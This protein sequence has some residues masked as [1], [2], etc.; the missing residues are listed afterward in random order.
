MTMCAWP[1]PPT[2]IEN[3]GNT[4]LVYPGMVEGKNLSDP[5][6]G[7]FTVV[8]LGTGLPRIDKIPATVRPYRQVT[9][10]VTGMNA[11]QLGE[12]L[13]KIADPEAVVDFRF[14][15]VLSFLPDWP[16]LT[17]QLKRQYYYCEVRMRPLFSTRHSSR[18][19]RRTNLAG[20]FFATDVKA[21]GGGRHPRR[22][23]PQ[24]FGH[25]ERDRGFT[26]GERTWVALS[27]SGCA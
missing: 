12:E 20:G 10:D 27:L 8:E 3:G 1:Y 2:S 13:K 11:A 4:L 6:T 24:L 5:G 15:G 22:T 21:D 23:A 18:R 26:R 14:T 25:G 7:F 16:L 17:E 9:L 19:G